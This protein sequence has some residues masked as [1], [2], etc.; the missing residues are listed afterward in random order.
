MRAPISRTVVIATFFSLL[1]LTPALAQNEPDVGADAN[2]V[3]DALALPDTLALPDALALP[4]DQTADEIAAEVDGKIVKDV[5]DHTAEDAENGIEEDAVEADQKG[6][7]DK[8][9]VEIDKKLKVEKKS[10]AEA[11]LNLEDKKSEDTEV[12]DRGSLVRMQT[13]EGVLWIELFDD[14]SPA[15][16]ASFLQH[17]DERHYEQTVFHRLVPGLILQGGGRGF[18]LR[19]ISTR[20]GPPSESDNGLSNVRLSVAMSRRLGSE[21]QNELHIRSEPAEFFINLTDNDYLDRQSSDDGV[22][23]TVFGRIIGSQSVL[24]ELASTPT[25]SYFDPEYPPRQLKY[26][27]RRP[28][29]IEKIERSDWQ[30]YVDQGKSKEVARESEDVDVPSE[31]ELI[32]LPA[33]VRLNPLL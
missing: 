33:G 1:A 30:A 5:D 24:E 22:G 25:K 4:D 31:P 15:T 14:Q 18:D 21:H 9:D 23:Y 20:I 12:E 2:E 29:Q 16:V 7:D 13:S 27:P 10:E 26:V 32:P 6:V 17:V 8:S 28:L 11:E 3:P 19:E